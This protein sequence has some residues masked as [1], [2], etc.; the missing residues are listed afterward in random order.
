MPTLT[1]N[2][3]L[4]DNHTRGTVADFLKGK[5]QDGSRLSVV[6]AYFTIYAYDALKD[7]LDHIDHL[8]FLFGEPS[9]VNRLDPSKTEKKAFIIDAD[10]LE[11]A[12][13]LQQ[14]HV[15]KECADWIERKVDIKT[16]KQSNLLHGKMYHVAT[17]GVEE[18]I[19]G[20]SNF[21]VRGLGLGN[22]DNNIEL[23]LI[24]DGHRDRQELKQWFDELWSHPN[25]VKDVKQEVLQYLKQ[26]YEDNAPEFIYYK[27]LFH[28]FEK[29]LYDTGKTDAELGQTSLF[30]TA[31]WQALFEFQKDG[32]KGAIN[33][34]LRY[35]GCIVADSV[36]LGK[37]YEALAVIK[38]FELKNER[39]LVLCPLKLRENW[40]VYKSNSRLNPF[41]ADR[42]RYD[43]L[44]H[45]DLS[46]ERGYSGDIN[47]ETLN[48]GNYDLVV[49]D[50][51]HN[52]RNNA[53]GKRDEA[54]SLIRKS[55]Y[56]RLM[57]EIIKAG[58]R[59]K[60][61]LLSATPVNNDLKDLRNQLYFLTEGSD[62]AFAETL[63][64]G[65]LKE[66]LAAAQKVFSVWARQ[67][68]SERKTS[69]LLEKLSA[70]FF[71]LLDGLT[72][73]RS[74]K[75]IQKYYTQTIAQLG[76]FPKRQKP[77]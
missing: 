59:T 30:E 9:F 15:A 52:F 43:V 53:P 13:K 27:T 66:T 60:V 56:Q 32:V 16:I 33:K 17:A 14:K 57:D 47:L 72:I 48:W 75:H 76:G 61:L 68:S 11:L 23:N 20:S 5:I 1:I 71:K 63:G 7:C 67:H 19:L 31:I 55:R 74:R 65:S 26:L 22:G 45:T 4:R 69:E 35:N 25:L 42:F 58:V 37:T 6:S 62:Q 46:R 34:I 29:F 70:A 38:Y 39:V 40:T 2:S 10:G 36:G 24:V 54:G 44:S 73:A 3:G 49:I 28:I 8:D 51:S 77:I 12:N 18:A 21:T 41:L 64:I 50:E